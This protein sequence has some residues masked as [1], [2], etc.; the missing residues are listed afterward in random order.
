MFMQKIGC[1]GRKASIFAIFVLFIENIY[2]LPENISTLKETTTLKDN[3]IFVKT[4]PF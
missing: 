1:A 2:L 3:E 4:S